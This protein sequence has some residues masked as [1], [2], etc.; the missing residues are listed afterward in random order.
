MKIHSGFISNS[1]SSSF[2]IKVGEPFDTVLEVAKYMI[3]KRGWKTDAELVNKVYVLEQNGPKSDAVSFRS[4]NYD[5]YIAKV[6]D[7]FLIQTCHNHDWDLGKFYC[8]CP[9][10]YAETFGDDTFYRLPHLM[11]FYNLEYGVTGRK[12]DWSCKSQYSDSW[13]RKCYSDYWLVNGIYKCLKCNT[14][15]DKKNENT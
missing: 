5:T 7:Y 4:C 12:L 2:I 14:E 8:Q 6:D 15:A 11:E 1:S 9:P 10:S 13:C 3:P